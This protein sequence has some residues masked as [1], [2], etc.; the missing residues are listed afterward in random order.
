MNIHWLK[1][2][3]AACFE[4]LWVIGLKHADDVWFWTGTVIAIY[5]SF[6]GLIMAG[7]HL[8]VGSVYAV[9]VGLGTAGTVMAEILWFGEPLMWNKV[10]LILLLLAGVIGLQL[11]SGQSENQT[12]KGRQD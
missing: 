4:V 6:Y 10:L 3:A 9:F 8:P 2:F 7:K 1:V 5:I 12:E 11:T